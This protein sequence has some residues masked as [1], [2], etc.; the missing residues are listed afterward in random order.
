MNKTGGVRSLFFLTPRNDSKAFNSMAATRMVQGLNSSVCTVIDHSVAI[1]CEAK[2]P[3]KLFMSN[4]DSIIE[5][6]I[7]NLR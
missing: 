5:Y 7:L 2:I 1:V 4:S 3:Q 6:L